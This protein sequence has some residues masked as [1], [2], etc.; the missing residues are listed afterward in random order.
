M[1]RPPSESLTPL[2]L[3]LMEILWRLGPST[4]QT[5][6]QELE[7]TRPLAYTSVQTMLNVLEKKGKAKRTKLDRAHLYSAKV[8][9]ETTVGRSLDDL[10]EKLFG[11]SAE[12]LVMNL[13]QSRKLSREKLAELEEMVRAKRGEGRQ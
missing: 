11:G 12:S 1:A 13:L 8:T 5:V 3:E 2:E 9:R 4:V 7:A 10:I 6:Q